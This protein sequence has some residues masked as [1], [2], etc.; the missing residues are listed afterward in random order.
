MV[1]GRYLQ[2]GT[3]TFRVLGLQ[4]AHSPFQVPHVLPFRPRCHG[5]L[6]WSAADLTDEGVL[7]R[8]V[9]AATPWELLML[10]GSGALFKW[11]AARL[12][13]ASDSCLGSR[14]VT[15]KDRNSG[16]NRVLPAL[17]A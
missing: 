3:W 12:A 11:P 15:P 5:N 10:C 7:L 1:L 4:G 9:S 6:W 8:A 14:V 13:A 17:T 2:L 16:P